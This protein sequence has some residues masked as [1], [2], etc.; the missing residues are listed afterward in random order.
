MDIS[1]RSRKRQKLW[2]L[3][4]GFPACVVSKSFTLIR[5][6][7]F[8]PLPKRPPRPRVE[9]IRLTRAVKNAWQAAFRLVLANCRPGTGKTAKAENCDVEA[10]CGGAGGD[11]RGWTFRDRGTG[12]AGTRAGARHR[13]FS[14]NHRGEDQ[15]A[16]PL[17]DSR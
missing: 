16:P 14:G 7:L 5:T 3:W 10:D 1:E 2:R 13:I 11:H 12:A 8:L 6:F 4:G 9:T 17:P 15:R